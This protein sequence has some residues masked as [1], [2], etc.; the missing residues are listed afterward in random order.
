MKIK[1]ALKRSYRSRHVSLIVDCLKH[2]DGLTFK[3]LYDEY[4]NR[5]KEEG[6]GPV[7]RSS[8]HTIIRRYEERGIVI[9]EKLNLYDDS[10]KFSLVSRKREFTKRIWL[11]K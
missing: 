11:V 1:E 9:R 10:S 7:C 8:L 2:E 5:C 3:K 6:I 4:C